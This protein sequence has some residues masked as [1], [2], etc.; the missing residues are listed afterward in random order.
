[1]TSTDSPSE[2]TTVFPTFSPTEEPTVSN[3]DWVDL[4]AVGNV[5][6]QGKCG[7]CWAFITVQSIESAYFIKYGQ[8]QFFS[9]QELVSC[10]KEEF[11][12]D[13]GDAYSPFGWI[14]AR[15]GLVTWDSYP[16]TSGDTGNTGTCEVDPAT[17]DPLSAPKS[18]V[19]VQTYNTNALISAITQQPVVVL[20]DASS[21]IFRYYR[22]GVINS[23]L[24][25]TGNINH[26]LVAVGYGVRDGQQY[27]KLKNQ[28]STFWGDAGYVYIASQNNDGKCGILNLNPI[29]PQL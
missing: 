19:R 17:R 8:S 2:E 12:C 7:S 20:V 15:G 16:Y 22:S 3:F 11:G 4:G 29:Y 13:G 9:V 25:F 6:N 28:W 26:G 21:D 27:I 1:M 5:L 10:D 18:V 14:S 24:C 23:P